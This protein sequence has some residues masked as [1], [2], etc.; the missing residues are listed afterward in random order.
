MVATLMTGSDL[1]GLG[2]DDGA[3]PLSMDVPTMKA[4]DRP[5]SDA[6]ALE[7]PAGA[8]ASGVKRLS[9]LAQGKKLKAPAQPADGSS[10]DQVP[11]KAVKTCAKA[12]TET[13]P[14]SLKGVSKVCTYSETSQSAEPGDAPLFK[15][16]AGSKANPLPKAKKPVESPTPSATTPPPGVVPTDDVPADPD[17]SEPTPSA[18][19]PSTEAPESRDDRDGAADQSSFDSASRSAV[20]P[21]S[22]QQAP[23]SGDAG[24]YF[25]PNWVQATT[26]TAPST[27]TGAASAYDKAN[28]QIV[29][30]GGRQDT[31]DTSD[32]T[33]VW[34]SGMWTQLNPA[35][36]P[37]S[38][39]YHTMAWSPE[40]NAVVMIGGQ[41]IAA[42]V[43][44]IFNDVW[45]WTG[46][47]WVQLAPTG[48]PPVAR[49]AASLV[50]SQDLQGL[51]LFGGTTGA[52]RNDTW[53]LKNNVWT[54]LVANG[55]AGAPPARKYAAMA[56]SEANGHIVM[57]GG[58]SGTC[59]G[60]D[61]VV[62]G[63]T[64]VFDN[65]AWAARSPAYVPP[66]RT[67]AA[68]TYDPGIGG[69]VM[70]GGY[71]A[72]ATTAT[73][74]NDTWAWNGTTWLKAAGIAS[75]PSTN[76]SAIASTDSGQ[77]VMYGRFGQVAGQTWTYDTNLPVL[78]IDITGG[79]EGT[80]V[81]PVFYAGDA[82]KVTITA[83]NTG[84]N[85][86]NGNRRTNVV[87]ALDDGS[88]LAGGSLLKWAGSLLGPCTTGSTSLCGTIE[89]L[90]VSVSNVTIPA[91]VTS[92]SVGNYV[93]TVLGSTRGCSIINIPAMAS[94]LF[95]ASA[96]VTKPMT[97][98]GGGLGTEDWWTYD[99]TDIG[100][101]GSA[102]VNVANG[103]LVVKQTDST[104]IQNHG[105]LAFSL[106]RVYN[107]QENMNSGGPLGAGWQFDIGET[108]ESAGSGF[109]FAGL[110]LPSLQSVTQPLSMTYV[111]R[112]GTRHVFSLRSLAATVGDVS[113]PIDLSGGV[114]SAGSSILGLLNPDTLPFKAH[115]TEDD[116][117]N[118]SG[119]CIDQAY[120]AP[121]GTDMYLF[122][123]VGV[124]TSA[125]TNAAADPETV[126]L[127]WSL[128]RPDRVRYDFDV[129]GHLIRTTDAAGNVMVY[130]PNLVRQY[131]PT[132]I[133]SKDCKPSHPACPRFTIDYN[134]GGPVAAGKRHVKVTDPAG[135][136]TSYVV[137]G[138]PLIPQLEQ[139]WDPGNPI[140]N[141]AGTRPS[142]EYTYSTATQKCAGS[143]PNTTT[144]GAM[145][146][147]AD[148][149]GKKTSFSYTP[150]FIDGTP[151]GADRVLT[152]TDRRGNETDGSTKGLRTQYT[153][154]YSSSP[155]VEDYVTADMAAPATFGAGTP[156]TGCNAN[157]A[158]QRNRYRSIDE[159]GR[160]GEIDQGSAND[161]YVK[162]TG[163]FWDGNPWAAGGTPGTCRQPDNAVDNNLC[164]VITRAVPRSAP[165]V[166]NDVQTDTI[167]G[168][169]VSDQGT[170]FQYGDMGQ[171]LRKFQVTNPAGGWSNANANITT[172]GTHDQYFDAD[173]KQRSFDN[174]VT[175]SGNVQSTA[176]GA[177]YA[178]VVKAD[179]PIAYYRMGDTS[180]PTMVD[181]STHGNN[182]TY[183]SSV[184]YGQP[185]AVPGNRAIG[186]AV[187]AWSGVKNS[188]NG[189]A[190]GTSAPDSDFTVESWVK[191]TS[192]AAEYTVN[193]GT[194]TNKQMYLGRY[195]GGFPWVVLGSNI[196]GG[197][198]IS[199]LGNTSISDGQYHHVVYTYDGSGTAAGLK[200][201]VDGQLSA[202]TVY[203]D[204]LDGPFADQGNIML[205]GQAGGPSSL[206]EVALYNKV[207]SPAR[208]DAHRRAAYGTTRVQAGTLYGVT[209]Q[210]QVLSP[211]GNAPGAAWGDYLTTMRLDVPADGEVASAN[212]TTGNSVCGDSPTGNT[213]LVCEVDTPASAG[214]DPGN[215]DLPSKNL[216]PGSPSAPTTSG[217]THTCTTY[218]YDAQGQRITMK[219]PKAH[220]TG[221]SDKTIYTYYKDVE[222][223]GTGGENP[224]A[225]NCDLTRKVSAGGWLK[226]VT[227]PDGKSVVYAYDRA[228]NVAR[229]WDRNAT[230]GKSLNADWTNA[231]NPP[232]AKYAENNFATPVTSA[233]LSTSY[234]GTVVVRPDGT[235]AG[236]GN[237]ASGELG[238]GSTAPKGIP[239]AAKVLT[240][241][242]QIGQTGNGAFSTCKITFALTGDGDVYMMGGGA[243]TPAKLA[244]L[245]NITSI[246]PGGCGLLA[247]DNE[248]KVWGWGSNS[249]GQIGDGS[250]GGTVST[251]VQVLAG[252]ASI[253]SGTA[254]SL[255]VKTDGSVWTWGANSSGQLG[256]GDTN[257]H[258]SPTKIPSFSRA[259]AVSAGVASSYVIKRD[260]SVWSFGDNTQGGLGIGSTDASSDTPKKITALGEGTSAG[261]VREV[262]GTAYGAAA[263]MTDG[264]VRAWGL[265]NVGQLGGAT[266]DPAAGSPVLIPDVSGQVA[267]AGGWATY[268]T[269]DRSGATTIWGDTSSNQRGDGTSPGVST[270]SAS[271]HT[272]SPYDVPW[273]YARGSR[274]PVGNLSTQV[275]N[276]AGE[277]RL[278]RPARGHAINTSAFDVT[279]TYDA[280]GHA[281]SSLTPMEREGAKKA[282]SA[283]DPFGNVVQ[284]IDPRG[285]A[286]LTQYDIV[287]RPVAMRTT[288]STTENS[289]GS[290]C[291]ETAA[292]GGLWSAQQVG[293][294]VCVLSSTYDGADQTITTTD[295]NSQTTKMTYDGAGRS[296]KQTAPRNDGVYTT[297]S[298]MWNYDRDGNVTDVCPPRQFDAAHEE[299]TTTG[300]TS[301]GAYS[302]HAT[303]DRAGRATTQKQYR[304]TGPSSAT[305][306]TSSVQFDAD[307]NAIKVVDANDH[308]TTFTYDLQGRRLTQS[309]PR[310]ES[311][312]Y[313][314]K[315]NYD[316][317]GNVTSIQ[318]PGSLNIGS[319]RDGRLVV[320]GTTAANSTDGVV[321]DKE[322]PFLIPDGAQY[323]S[324]K[325]QGG[326]WIQSASP[327][328]LMFS[329]TE[330]VT[331][332]ATCGID[333]KGTGY[334]G[335]AGGDELLGLGNGKNAQNPNTDEIKGNGGLGGVG[336]IS[337]V[338]PAH[339][340]GGGGHN[341]P[342][343][344]GAPAGDPANRGG[345][346]SGTADFTDV[347]TDYLVGSGGGGGGGGEGI[348][349]LDPPGGKGGDGGGYVRITATKITVDGQV[350]ASGADGA[351]VTA[352]SGGG[353]GGAGGG[354]WLAAP[355]IELASETALNVT[356]G[357]GGDSADGNDGGNGAPGYVRID[358][359]SVTNVP[360]G[361]NRTR[362][363]NI[364]SYSYDANNRVVDTLGGAQTLNADPAVDSSSRAVPDAQG[365]FNTRTRNIYD[366]EGRVVSVL[367]PQAFTNAASLTD[368][369]TD[370]AGRIDFNLN[371]QQVATYDPR[372]NDAVDDKGTGNDGGTGV[373]QQ[374]AQCPTGAKPQTVEGLG[375]YSS[376]VGVCVTRT[377]Y[378]ENGNVAVAYLATSDGGDNRRLEYTY[379]DDNLLLS[380]TGPDPSGSGRVTMAKTLYDGVGR[381]IKTLDA[382]VGGNSNTTV[383][384]YTSDGH[385][386]WTNEQGYTVDSAAVTHMT[387]MS[388]D[389]NGQETR[390]IAPRGVTVGSDGLPASTNTDY[391]ATTTYTSDG[392][393]AAIKTPG[394]AAGSFNT[395]NYTYDQVGNP[396]TVK[397]PEQVAAGGSGKASVNT[398]TWD[399][400]IA[401]SSNPIG[402]SSYRTTRYAYTPSGQKSAVEIARCSSSDPGDC[403]PSNSAWHHGGTTRFTY[404]P[405][406]LNVD[407]I[408]K[409]NTSI[410]K[411]YDQ[412]G[413]VKKVTDPTSDI[414][415]TAS[416]YLDGLLRTVADGKNSNTY[417]YDARGELSARS[418]ETPS[419]GV[420]GGGVKRTTYAYNDAGLPSKMTSGVNSGNTTSMSYDEA[421][422][423]TQSTDSGGS[424]QSNHYSYRP[425]DALA[426]V[427]TK[428]S[429]NTVAKFAYTYDNNGNIKSRAVS[430]SIPDYVD[431][432]TYNPAD[433]VT[434][435]G[436][437]K[438]SAAVVATDY[439]WDRNAN[440][441]SAK[442]DNVG[443]EW[444]YR[445]DN[446]INTQT[447]GGSSK[448][449]TYDNAGRLTDDGC[450]TYTYDDFDRM[451]KAVLA[452]AGCGG[453][454]KTTTYTYDGLDRQRS[455]AVSGS[456]TSGENV[457]TRTV[458]DGLS[459][460]MVGQTS[461][462][463][464]TH[465]APD[466]LYQLD[467][468]GAHVA[469]Q[470]TGDG[471]ATSYL[472]NDGTGTIS[473]QITTGGNTVCSA[474]Y[475]PFGSPVDATSS[476]KVCGSGGSG[477]DKTGNAAWYRDQT[478]DGSTGNYQLGTRTYNPSTASFTS[479]DSYRVSDPGTDLSVGT[480]P[481]TQNTYT[482]VNGNPVNAYDPTG[483]RI[484]C[485]CKSDYNHPGTYNAQEKLDSHLR[486][487]KL[488]KHKSENEKFDIAKAALTFLG[489]ASGLKE[490]ERC[491]VDGSMSACVMTVAGILGPGAVLKV[492]KAGRAA[493]GIFRAYRAYKKSAKATRAFLKSAD[494]V[495]AGLA[496]AAKAERRAAT[497][498]AKAAKKSGDDVVA[499]GSKGKSIRKA[500]ATNGKRA[501][502]PSGSA[503][504]GVH[505][506]LKYKDGWSDAQR[507]AADLK[508]QK[509]NEAN[510]V[511]TEPVRGSTSA[512]K[513]FRAEGNDVP[514]GH[515]IDHIVD[516]QLGGADTVANM[517]PLDLS[518]NRSLGAQ[519]Y[520]QTRDLPVGTKICSI[521]IGPGGC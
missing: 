81:V 33:W 327:V 329:A 67:A 441:T 18:P 506:S 451:A 392:L 184:Q 354:I 498:L 65:G 99:T 432:F 143:A 433:N 63:D 345:L 439:T 201:Y 219:S 477:A 80:D 373:N 287:N 105:K 452:S 486:K 16:A 5:E 240:N 326:G 378:D 188:L 12:T 399:N 52:V 294:K 242:V 318:A 122:R 88:L 416:Y 502:G 265:N 417:A 144:I 407:Q 125:C 199:V 131:G 370:T 473:T 83:S 296:V 274:D 322:H 395:T 232:S 90:A 243:S 61:C 500:D 328:G 150:A 427:E 250:A 459:T 521:S 20:Q 138:D 53:L 24:E 319:G 430:G 335:G 153:Y 508:V 267:I 236:S 493:A 154:N 204:T 308:D 151:V 405:N 300:C 387:T 515:D 35:V 379:S 190:S 444:S 162:Q 174:S 385:T 209:D 476:N 74:R 276:S 278:S 505:L 465:S 206:D 449:Y 14:Y 360:P 212:K 347:G 490:L 271:G 142:A 381:T 356:G 424:G 397:S 228:G 481:L 37:P 44:T 400:M 109:G 280:A 434:R 390:T 136:V 121:P 207:L 103:N 371:G 304:V 382:S 111:D 100:N 474:A 110:K 135:R 137:G 361:A 241:I 257:T 181:S 145:C 93:A 29:L 178:P 58:S 132:E 161:Q 41:R 464:G 107:S 187:N 57:F 290:G 456:S 369:K 283:Y 249:G 475:D 71:T 448:T 420:T 469:M 79:P 89:S 227:D 223:C 288:R 246:A 325:V 220:E 343:E 394:T 484:L 489:E 428:V 91:G 260:G 165:F 128:V 313:S 193:Y 221:S 344:P 146:S 266:T 495:T 514:T 363:A 513:V 31:G 393:T 160:I 357:S 86:I 324:V 483:H 315:W 263:L 9:D 92:T 262:V 62:F 66:A 126:T 372:Y 349:V 406:G 106:G 455:S 173:G 156:A 447:V 305:A 426:S 235:V 251:P 431:T 30:F 471:A 141:D 253:G 485:D 429:G 1:P 275:N 366:P 264:R 509:L 47:T 222:T 7:A 348:L 46:T 247:L 437:K 295:Q 494:E 198:Y 148:A 55:A 45:K 454:S 311:K 76:P 22:F 96:T 60:A 503:D 302:T 139:V 102:N 185:G 358:A 78:S 293:H 307:G 11:K 423:L 205:L 248:G 169:T 36:K 306:L 70:F 130:D 388:Y 463:N 422:R 386:K 134:A 298:T 368:P 341:G 166:L 377:K 95:G 333:Q 68:M 332:C 336:G 402:P 425:D 353:G 216:A 286:T 19:T 149:K 501:Q 87:S 339:A 8:V 462:T 410:T 239:E 284:S 314:T 497:S 334:D 82:A 191:S 230:N 245:S 299:N 418:D 466:V 516:L 25:S 309:A 273:K 51:V 359:D 140:S 202:L 487:V 2:G 268:L 396:L 84:I 75:P 210:T 113:L 436:H 461:A 411:E 172:Y 6:V 421:G 157:A 21:A 323:R 97:V 458:F 412:A 281:V 350:D 282:T 85:P 401:T 23:Q 77:V 133:Y 42:G 261:L 50:W 171:L 49:A 195:T 159:R 507:A 28:H 446:S 510:L 64:W 415:I 512:S 39:F 168:V 208:I 54:Q 269:A 376:D 115:P 438:G 445:L 192:T 414:T 457:T 112:D 224:N 175:G 214:V 127:G 94:S 367:P 389:A 56:Y 237:N 499:A 352:A 519:I 225:L 292:A 180:G 129:L 478:R 517:S 450:T 365:L 116:D 346:A 435:Y 277:R 200:I 310:S 355:E 147:V 472:N 114:G 409:D 119:L 491:V 468:S 297:L 520:H 218:T 203:S 374:T 440:R 164:Q 108:G 117:L 217:Y 10:A 375:S 123:Y 231:A 331:V 337:S 197:K 34:A 229:T 177:N 72:D 383:L 408:G 330:D 419:A 48:T 479:P 413:R 189:F 104:P 270:P 3:D 98:C 404:A 167:D 211:R 101:G 255:A 289:E 258:N 158:C 124:G 213:G 176:G 518:V 238:T 38:R 320:D 504:D 398:F 43:N 364:T 40:H 120:K 233:A 340:G 170:G 443:T 186:E 511:K 73:F 391:A 351:D 15:P 470:Q 338:L 4:G 69:A 13:V 215:C 194:D 453:N 291:T 118:Y 59:V 26:P 285:N 183:T 301:T 488:Q 244:G 32:Q 179:D 342:G 321:H 254:H 403:T 467:S 460:T 279:A 272:I 163:Y 303:Y 155:T 226:A 482:Y 317:A 384:A 442:I 259:A 492:G 252:V 316:A 362:A 496:K 152:V 480:D 234:A 196:A 27:P 380:V 312:R 17:A 182:A 256:L